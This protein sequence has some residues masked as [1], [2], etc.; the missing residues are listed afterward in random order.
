MASTCYNAGRRIFECLIS[1]LT[2][3]VVHLVSSSSDLYTK[4]KF[5]KRHATGVSAT[6]PVE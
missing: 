4:Y 6:M 1:F 5:Y 2:K 3:M